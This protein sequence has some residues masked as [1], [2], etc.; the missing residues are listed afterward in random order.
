MRAFLISALLGW[1]GVFVLGP[2]WFALRSWLLPSLGLLAWVLLALRQRRGGNGY[3]LLALPLFALL[4]DRHLDPYQ[5]TLS[6]VWEKGV[7]R[8]A[9][10][11]VCSPVERQAVR[12]T[13]TFCLDSP[14]HLR[15]Q[16]Q[17]VELG[18]PLRLRCYRCPQALQNGDHYRIRLSLYP[19]R[20]LQNP[21]DWFAWQKQWRYQ[22]WH[23]VVRGAPRPLNAAD[24]G[25]RGLV[26]RYSATM[27][28]WI[29]RQLAPLDHRPTLQAM[30]IGDASGLDD[31]QWRQLRHSGLI[32]LVVVSGLHVTLMAALGAGGVRWLCAVAGFRQ[33]RRAGFVGGILTVFAYLAL[34]GFAVPV[35]RASLM[36]LMG[37]FALLMRQR[38]A[39][40]E[41]YLAAV[42]GTLWVDPFAFVSPG[43]WLSFGA[44]LILFM[45]VR[46]G[47]P[48]VGKIKQLG[49]LVKLQV[50]LFVGLLPL[51]AYAYGQVSLSGLVLNLVAVPLVT[52]LIVP[53]SLMVLIGQACLG[54][55]VS[56]R[57]FSVA[58]DVLDALLSIFWWLAEWGDRIPLL[59]LG[60]LNEGAMLALVV[61]TAFALCV[62]HPLLRIWLLVGTTLLSIRGEAGLPVDQDIPEF[63]LTLLDVGQGLSVVMKQGASVWVYDTGPGPGPGRAEGWD[64]GREVIVPFLAREGVGRLDALV[65]SH[66][67]NDHAG[68]ALSVRKALPTSSVLL[69]EPQRLTDLGGQ[70]CQA[71]QR[72][73]IGQAQVYVL[74]PLAGE[75][76]RFQRNNRSCVLRVVYGGRS[77]L[78]PGDLEIKAQRRL[79]EIYGDSLRADVLL[80]PHHGAKSS[81]YPNLI[82]A[83]QPTRV[84]VSAGYRNPFGHPHRE[85]MDWLRRRDI[86][87]V[88]TV[89]DGAVQLKWSPHSPLELRV[90]GIAAD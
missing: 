14:L 85:V 11:R 50:A 13:F 71:G 5:S 29:G 53:V 26:G 69:G 89:R 28:G 8:V 67:D 1:S 19:R 86:P 48:P 47:L 80:L 30:L 9:E 68:G 55:M 31:A 10:G 21:G 77:V 12:Q 72:L 32:H 66:G 38:L 34:V 18:D 74:W 65:V 2:H 20:P 52:V 24:T 88:S 61:V 40:I 17:T 3:V 22:A 6:P 54:A 51:L 58:T 73:T 27:Q 63:E 82:S 79:V 46:P 56:E 15:R 59:E 33:A 25:W 36:S 23:G 4:A 60:F 83:V 75:Q 90:S 76:K 87:V 37:L 45:Q 35:F 81:F 41:C 39:L 44:V 49:Q 16:G 62:P 43:F 64:A 42:L 78:L 57:V 7:T 84:L 70:P